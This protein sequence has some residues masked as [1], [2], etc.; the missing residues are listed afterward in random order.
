MDPDYETKYATNGK[1]MF[2]STV[3]LFLLVI[4]LLFVHTFRHSCFPRRNHAIRIPSKGLL[5]CSLKFL[6]IFTYS[7]NTHRSLHDC[8]VYLS[9]FTDGQQ[10]R[11]LPNCNHV[12]HAHCIDAW[13]TSHSNCPLCRIT[14]HRHAIPVQPF[15]NT[16]PASLGF[17]SFPASV[18]CPRKS[19]EMVSLIVEL[20]GGRD[21]D[22][23]R[24]P[25]ISRA[26]N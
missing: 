5:P 14:V 4:V 25:M 10:C 22:P 19:L 9:E 6:P 17:S 13:F 23:G 20:K 1:V 3:L 12:F 7:S 24:G 26:D 2:G 15:S 21:P 8:A 11:V 18:W 16:E